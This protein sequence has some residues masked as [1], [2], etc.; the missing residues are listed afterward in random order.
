MVRAVTPVE[1]LRFARMGVALT[2]I[3]FFEAGASSMPA[4]RERVEASEAHTDRTIR[5]YLE[6]VEFGPAGRD[7]NGVPSS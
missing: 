1:T 2:M 5:G 4:L 6:A 7:S 3:Q